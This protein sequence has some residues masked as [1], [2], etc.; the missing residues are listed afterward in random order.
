MGLHNGDQRSGGMDG[1]GSGRSEPDGGGGGLRVAVRWCG[2]EACW[3]YEGRARLQ[4]DAAW[5]HSKV[6][7]RPA[8]NGPEA[9]KT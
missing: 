8:R 5:E 9:L 7:S 3:A 2:D 6:A 4:A 1:G